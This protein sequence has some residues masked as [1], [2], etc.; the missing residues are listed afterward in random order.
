MRTEVP[1]RVTG[2]DW[3]VPIVEVHVNGDGPHD[4]VLDTGSTVSIVSAALAGKLGIEGTRESE[5]F[6]PGGPAPISTTTLDSL[7][8]GEA[9]AESIA[10][11]ILDLEEVGSRM[12]VELGGIVGYNFLK[13]YRVTID[14]PGKRLILEPN[15]SFAEP[16]EMVSTGI[17]LGTLETF[18][19]FVVRD[20]IAG[21]PA[22]E[23]GV[24]EGDRLVRVDDRPA[25][26]Y[27]MRQLRAMM[28]DEGSELRLQLA[29]GDQALTAV[30]KPR[31]LL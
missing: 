24:E 30:V 25:A 4:F 27:T 9:V 26:S 6:T 11:A 16:E 12:G 13:N 1:F 3:A 2:T 7:K 15:D 19:E 14:Y 31:R 10:A 22:A 18:S 28:E 21:S 23:A 17:S 20:V 29:R 5:A 8:L